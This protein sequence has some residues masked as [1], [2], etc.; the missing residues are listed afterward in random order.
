VS[1][2]DLMRGAMAT[3]AFGA[4]ADLNIAE[5]RADGPRS[6]SELAEST[7]VDPDLLMLVLAGGRE[8]TEP[9]WRALLG[10]TG[11]EVTDIDDELVQAVCR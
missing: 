10:E 9:E 4:A 2:W 8:R 3:K 11:F 5:E 1:P 7:G 6:V